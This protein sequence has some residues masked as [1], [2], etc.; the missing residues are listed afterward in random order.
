MITPLSLRTSESLTVVITDA[1]GHEINYVVTALY[2]T[3]K[4][5]KDVGPVAV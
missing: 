3:M 5:G 2:L 4:E 1:A